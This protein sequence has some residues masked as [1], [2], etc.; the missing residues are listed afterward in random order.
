MVKA[1]EIYVDNYLSTEAANREINEP[2]EH[3]K[4]FKKLSYT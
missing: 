3:N 4:S 1:V 2:L